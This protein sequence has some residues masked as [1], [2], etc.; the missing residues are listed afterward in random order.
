MVWL[1]LLEDC[2]VA[3][4]LLKIY[5]PAQN[6]LFWKQYMLASG[7]WDDAYS[8]INTVYTWSYLKIF[9]DFR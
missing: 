9:P 5:I 6:G 1:I 4:K 2:L 8:V 3:G 7:L